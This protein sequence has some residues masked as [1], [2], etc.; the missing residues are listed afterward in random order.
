[1]PESFF[2]ALPNR[3]RG[4]VD[5]GLQEEPELEQAGDDRVQEFPAVVCLRCRDRRPGEVDTAA[6]A[7]IP[8]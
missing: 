6:S 4:Q 7:R 5:S 3:V 8:T 2:D 1:M